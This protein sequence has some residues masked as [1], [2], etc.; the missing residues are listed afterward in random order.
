MTGGHKSK[1]LVTWLAFLGGGLGLHR[2]YLHGLRDVLGWAWAAVTLVGLQGVRLHVTLGQDH[3]AA[4]VLL[5]V[6]GLSLSAGALMAL[7]HGLMPDDRWNARYNPQGPAHESGWLTVVGVVLALLLGA[8]VLMS[9]IA[10]GAQR[11]FEYAAEQEAAGQA[12]S[13]KLSQ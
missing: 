2:F 5:P 13:L 10:F 9:A 11:W 6:L 3:H 1:T 4:W 8:G 7:V 12:N